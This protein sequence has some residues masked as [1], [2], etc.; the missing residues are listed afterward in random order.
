ML[1]VPGSLKKSFLGQRLLAEQG[2][3]RLQEMVTGEDIELA[4][5]MYSCGNEMHFTLWNCMW[6]CTLDR[7]VET[8]LS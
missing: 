7:K 6:L 1:A 4:L 8:M 5:R 3:S 2:V